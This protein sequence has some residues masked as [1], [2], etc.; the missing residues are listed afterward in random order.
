MKATPKAAGPR[1]YY[2]SVI[3]TLLIGVIVMTSS[4]YGGMTSGAIAN[5]ID[6]PICSFIIT[7]KGFPRNNMMNIHRSTNF[8]FIN[9]AILTSIRVPFSGL[10]LLAFPIRAT[11]FFMAPLPVTVILAFLPTGCTLIRTKA[12]CV[13]AALYNVGLHLNNLVALF[14]CQPSM[15]PFV[16][17]FFRASKSPVLLFSVFIDPK[18]FTTYLTRLVPARSFALIRT[19][20]RAVNAFGPFFWLKFFTAYLAGR[21]GASQ[22]LSKT[23]RGAKL[24]SGTMGLKRLTTQT[25]IKLFFHTDIISHFG[26]CCKMRFAGV[27]KNGT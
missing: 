20:I 26:M 11:P 7:L 10:V 2:Y 22:C 27:Y 21:K 15:A 14:T 24:L 5:K 23:P 25:A 17:A 18:L 13:L 3:V 8:F 6:Q 12:P 16:A 9:S 4:F 1:I 19:F